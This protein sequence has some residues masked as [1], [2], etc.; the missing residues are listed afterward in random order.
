MGKLIDWLLARAE[1]AEQ[2]RDELQARADKAYDEAVA[3]IPDGGASCHICMAAIRKECADRAVDYVFFSGDNHPENL[4]VPEISS[5]GLRA[6]IEEKARAAGYDNPAAV[7]ASVGIKKYGVKKMTKLAQAAK[8][9]N[10]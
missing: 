3:S 7:A 2:E 4:D 8:K 5:I 9:R 6:A 10:N 1:K